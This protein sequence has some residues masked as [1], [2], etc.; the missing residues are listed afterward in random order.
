M[1]VSN[2]RSSRSIGVLAMDTPLVA[3]RGVAA[4]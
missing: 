4:E 1:L 3:S 2:C